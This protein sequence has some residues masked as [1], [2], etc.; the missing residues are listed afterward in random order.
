MC[1]SRE[2]VGRSVREQAVA[3]DDRLR[4]QAEDQLS[5][6]VVLDLAERADS[7]SQHLLGVADGVD[8]GAS[9]WEVAPRERSVLVD[10]VDAILELVRRLADPERQGRQLLAH[11]GPHLAD[12]V[13][14][15]LVAV[16]T[17]TADEPDE[18]LGLVP[19]VVRER[20]GRCLVQ[21]LHHGEAEAV[22][23]LDVASGG[24]RLDDGL[25]TLEVLTHVDD[26]AV[27]AVVLGVER[28]AGHVQ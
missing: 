13:G 24:Q 12:G 28:Q 16:G 5:D 17:P 10:A 27:L 26:G 18:L 3:D 21:R 11:H 8:G 20:L 15:V 25:E 7:A 23:V 4:E 2:G 14:D 1:T 6:D 19:A 9:P 22:L